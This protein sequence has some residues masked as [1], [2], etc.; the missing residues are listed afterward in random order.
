LSRCAKVVGVSAR[1]LQRWDR[2]EDGGEDRRRG[3]N[4]VPGNKLSEH[5]ERRLLSVLTSPEYRDLSPRQVIPALAEQGTY[6]ASEATAYRVLHKHDMQKHRTNKRPATSKKPDE[7]VATAPNQVLCWDITYLR[8]NILG[9]FFYL[10]LVTDIFSRRI[11]AARVH[12]AENDEY[13]AELFT[14]VQEREGLAPGETTL[15]ADNGSAMKGATLKATLER[16]GVLTS[17]SRPS[18]SDDNPFVESLFGTMKTRV[19]YP[20]KPFATLEEAQAWVDRFVCWYNEEHRHSA[21]NW[22]TPMARHTGE[23]HELLR[24]REE[25]YRRAQQRHPQ[26]WSRNIRDCSPAPAVTLNPR[27]KINE[28]ATAA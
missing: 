14:E 21:L 15:H 25:T 27:K 9:T 23:D 7:L 19:G 17:Y 20:K 22:V 3:P 26:R 13:A 6:I 18:V 16:L 1:T 12:E 2:E 28:V 8:R 24:R 5:E 11:V 10:Y 4:T